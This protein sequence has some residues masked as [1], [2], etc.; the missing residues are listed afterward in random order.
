[1]DT[2]KI[3]IGSDHAGFRAKEKLKAILAKKGVKI[4]D[5]GT[6]SQDSVDYP[7]Y[8]AK[9]ARKVAKTRGSKGILICGS[10]IGMVIVANK[11]RGIRA[12]AAYDN[13]TARMSRNDNDTN[14]LCLRGRGFPFGK[15]RM[16]VDVWLKTPFSGKARHKRR[17]DKIRKLEI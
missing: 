15:S 17:I 12:V 11:V 4:D 3:I 14:V 16:I 7:D 6:N 13:Y 9:V 2:T 1:M 8:A 10:G 5:V